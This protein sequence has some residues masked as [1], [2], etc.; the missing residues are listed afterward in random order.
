MR[1]PQPYTQ[2]IREALQDTAI[3]KASEQFCEHLVAWNRQRVFQTMRAMGRD[4]IFV[5]D[6]LV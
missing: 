3:V 2:A 1:N 5:S 4:N 6:K